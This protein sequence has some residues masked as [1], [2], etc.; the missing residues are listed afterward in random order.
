MSQV[1]GDTPAEPANVTGGCAPREPQAGGDEPGGD[2]KPTKACKPQLSEED[3]K[4]AWA[5]QD[6]LWSCVSP[7]KTNFSLIS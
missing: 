4:T 5:A 6:C 7:L 3:V 1:A 2:S